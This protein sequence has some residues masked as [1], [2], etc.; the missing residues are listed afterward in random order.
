MGAK[1]NVITY[2]CA[3]DTKSE[4]RVGAI[5]LESVQL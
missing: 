4:V 1:I 5:L 3:I 2:V